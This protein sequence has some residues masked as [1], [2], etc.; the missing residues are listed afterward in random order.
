MRW[1]LF[2]LAGLTLFDGLLTYTTAETI[3]QQTAAIT[4][5][6]LS[7]ILLSGAAIV[8]AVVSLKQEIKKITGPAEELAKKKEDIMAAN[9]KYLSDKINEK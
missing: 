2:L 3:M 7:G 8:D 1:I 6:V 4:I 5:L 9:E